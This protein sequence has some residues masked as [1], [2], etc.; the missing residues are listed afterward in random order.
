MRMYDPSLPLIAI[1]IPKT[2]GV[3]VRQLYQ[4]W[5]GNGFFEHYKGKGAGFPEKRDLASVS[6]K[7][8]SVVVYGHF[9]RLR[10]LGIEQYY[11]EV[12]QFVTIMRDP[13][14]RAVS[15]YF[16]LNAKLHRSENDLKDVIMSQI[17]EW[18]ML[19]HF[20]Q[21]VTME[22]Y[23]DVIENRFIEVGVL[24][25]MDE[26]LR[27]IAAKLNKRYDPGSLNRLNVSVKDIRIPHELREAFIEQNPLEYAVYNYVLEK[28]S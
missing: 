3:S 5:F 13:F 24:E 8:T 26:S 9:N 2:G 7:P 12:E 19:C 18:S 4:E 16:Y 11:P 20:P 25:Y 22:N 27:R 15:R 14:E 10:R 21:N 6:S 1:H 28:Y 23:R 17:P